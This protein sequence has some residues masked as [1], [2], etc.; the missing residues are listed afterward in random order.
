MLRT[1]MYFLYKL[2]RSARVYFLIC[3]TTWVGVCGA[4]SCCIR[5]GPDEERILDIVTRR[6]G[7]RNSGSDGESGRPHTLS[8]IPKQSVLEFYCA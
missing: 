4:M 3:W 7:A 5:C 6:D 1:F 2:V 8:I